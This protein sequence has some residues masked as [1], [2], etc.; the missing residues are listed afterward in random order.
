MS[1]KITWKTHII[2]FLLALGLAQVMN[3]V[4]SIIL[5][6][7]F[8]KDFIYYPTHN[9]IV[10]FYINIALIM[11]PVSI[12]HELIHGILYKFFGGEVKYGYKI[13]YAYTH[14]I[15]ELALERSKFL[16]VLLAPVVVISLVS[17]LLPAWIGGM[18]YFVNLLGSVGDLYMA[19]ILC[20]YRYDS[21][22]IDRKY[23]FDVV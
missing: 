6:N 3:N 11:I 12:V 19:F 16:V 7:Y 1:F 10:N 15:S 22:I 20:K 9:L 5:D 8:T 17:L 2:C 23:G 21:R 4:S 18:I 13:I 14:E